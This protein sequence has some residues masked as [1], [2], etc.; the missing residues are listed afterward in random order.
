MRE[1]Y[2]L[3]SFLCLAK[4]KLGFFLFTEKEEKQLGNISINQKPGKISLFRLLKKGNIL[5]S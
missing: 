5:F 2:K 4:N 1:L 3:S